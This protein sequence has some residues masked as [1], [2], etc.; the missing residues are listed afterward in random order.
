[1]IYPY[2]RDIPVIPS[3]TAM[4]EMYDHSINIHYVV[5][6]LKHGYDCPRSKRSKNIIEKCIDKKRKTIRVVIANSY[7]YSLGTEVWVITH[8]G[9]TSKPEM[10][11]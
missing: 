8:V 1:M 5:E 9:I 3:R 2:F 10:R 6:I 11:K 4:N 7:N